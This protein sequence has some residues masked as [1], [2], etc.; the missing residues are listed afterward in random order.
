MPKGNKKAGYV[1]LL[2]AKHHLKKKP[3]DYENGTKKKIANKIVYNMIS[4]PS[5]YI[6]D[7]YAPKKKGRKTKPVAER[8]TKGRFLKGEREK[9]NTEQLAQLRENEKAR[10]KKYREK[11]KLEGKAKPSTSDFLT[12]SKESYKIVPDKS[13]NGFD[14]IYATPTIQGWLNK[15]T[16]TILIGVRGTKN[17]DKT[18]WSANFGLPFN[19]LTKSDRYKKDK[20]SVM[21]LISQFNPQ[22]YEYYVSG[23]SLGGAVSSQLKRDFPFIKGIEEYNPAF[24]SSD[25]LNQQ[26]DT[27]MRHYVDND[28]LYRAG[29]FLFNRK[30]VIAPK[31]QLPPLGAVGEVYNALSAHNLDNFDLKGGD[32]HREIRLL[33]HTIQMY[34]DNLEELKEE[35]RTETDK[36]QK[37]FLRNA[38]NVIKEQLYNA[39]NQL[40][41]LS[42]PQSRGG[43]R[44]PPRPLNRRL[45]EHLRNRLE[46]IRNEIDMFNQEIQRTHDNINHMMTGLNNI[47][48]KIE[49]E[50]DNEI[51]IGNRRRLLRNIELQEEELQGFHENVEQLNSQYEEIDNQLQNEL[52]NENALEGGSRN[53][54]YVK[55]LL[56][57]EHQ[58]DVDIFDP[59]KVSNPS[60]YIKKYTKKITAKP[61][62]KITEEEMKKYNELMRKGLIKSVAKKG[63]SSLREKIAKKKIGKPPVFEPRKEIGIGRKRAM[64]T[65]AQ[66]LQL[67]EIL[68]HFNNGIR[69][70]ENKKKTDKAIDKLFKTARDEYFK[71]EMMMNDKNPIQLTFSSEDLSNRLTNKLYGTTL[72]TEQKQKKS[73]EL[74]P[75]KK[76]LIPKNTHLEPYQQ[77]VSE[78]SKL[79]PEEIPYGFKWLKE[80]YGNLYHTAQEK[81]NYINKEGR[82][83]FTDKEFKKFIHLDFDDTNQMK[84]FFKDILMA[85]TQLYFLLS[86]NANKSKAP[87]YT[88]SFREFEKWK[89][90]N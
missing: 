41:K 70:T 38:I 76:E 29:G 68:A 84:D 18:D 51:L 61:K 33:I 28:P 80:K 47:N 77:G 11:K 39:K 37:R 36:E 67:K 16:N 8:S 53:A 25:I 12:A 1:G 55:K 87:S 90:G 64:L 62:A 43:R 44:A 57:M 7:L 32:I 40:D 22:Q 26:G 49:R 50:P 73:E 34:E 60:E 46:Q 59:S 52:Q 3:A 54:G 20:E 23:H 82:P 85:D 17:L 6:T 69:S 13:F 27:I 72:P 75:L 83:S 74:L 35:L 79:R 4:K 86:I 89:K 58:L 42:P 66:D 9:L 45:I 2:L 15:N 65:N 63:I 31:K 10:A 5:Q 78:V 71:E 19:R 14:L 81:A 24:Q 56:A 21:A 88:S 30:D 48:T